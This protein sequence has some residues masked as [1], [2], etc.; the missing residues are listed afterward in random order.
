MNYRTILDVI[1]TPVRR[2]G[3][4]NGT[5]STRLTSHRSNVSYAASM[6]IIY[7]GAIVRHRAVYSRYRLTR[8]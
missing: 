7:V 1:A 5:R 3:R 4:R 8:P 6:A 2:L